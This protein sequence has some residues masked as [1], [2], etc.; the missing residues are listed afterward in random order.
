MK[1]QRINKTRLT[2]FCPKH[3]KVSIITISPFKSGLDY[4]LDLSCGCDFLA[5]SGKKSPYEESIPFG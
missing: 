1:D 4:S 5:K 3:G 2:I